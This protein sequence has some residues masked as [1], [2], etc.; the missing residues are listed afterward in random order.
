MTRNARWGWT[1]TGVFATGIC[2]LLILNGC[3]TSRAA[4][5]QS[6][7]RLAPCPSSPNCV[8]SQDPD[9]S[10]HIEA[11]SYTGERSDAHRRLLAAIATIPRCEIVSN[12]TTDHVS[13]LHVTATTLIMRYTD[14]L[15]FIID[16]ANKRIEVR[17]LSR[18]GYSDL[19]VN[20]RRVE[21]LRAAFANA[22]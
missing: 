14:D 19:G 10:H 20:R 12:I 5:I 8:C 21:A 15:E 16:D 9:S 6:D 7:G 18:I 2:C 3:A 22:K 4:G 17:S 13:Y 1:L 11:F